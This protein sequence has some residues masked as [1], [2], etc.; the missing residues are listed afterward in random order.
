MRQYIGARYVPKFA[1]PLTWDNTHSYEALVMVDYMGDTFTSKKP[2]PA[3]VAI[4]NT[5]YWVMTGS[6]N[7]QISALSYRVDT[8]EY[9]FANNIFYT[10]PEAHGAKGDGVTDD[11]AAFK[12][13]LDTG[14]P[15]YCKPGANYMLGLIK[16]ISSCYIL[17]NNST[18][19]GLSLYLNTDDGDN[20]INSYQKRTCYI[21]NVNFE[22]STSEIALYIGGGTI[23]KNVIFN[24][25][26]RAVQFTNNYIDYVRLD[27]IKTQGS[28]TRTKSMFR[29]PSL[30]D[31]TLII[32]A[33]NT[34]GS[35]TDPAVY[36]V[37]QSNCTVFEQCLNLR[38]SIA[39]SATVTIKDCH[40]E[41]GYIDSDGTPSATIAVKRCYFWGRVALN[42]Y[43][44]YKDCTFLINN[45]TNGANSNW[46]MYDFNLKNC[47]IIIGE[48]NS[49]G[50]NT[51]I[52]SDDTDAESCA[53]TSGTN[54]I[55]S[56]AGSIV[57]GNFNNNFDGSTI[58]YIGYMTSNPNKMT[59][60]N[61]YQSEARTAAPAQGYGVRFQK[62]SAYDTSYLYLIRTINNVSEYAVIPPHTSGNYIIDF[63]FNVN[64][65][66]WK[67]FTGT[68]PTSNF[69]YSRTRYHHIPKGTSDCVNTNERYIDGTTGV[70]TVKL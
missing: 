36:E 60:H 42:A 33:H 62:G 17:G 35:N 52:N 43:A 38:I 64:G 26:D 27:S 58:T 29:L 30:S 8:L 45:M 34:E 2:V 49:I 16:G 14:L 66:K 4:S 51:I 40:F 20:W 23:L 13:A 19:T 41:N 22:C 50:G 32:N 9:D 37:R 54:S 25:Y 46:D 28:T 18:F 65:V 53:P 11:T 69:D 61:T 68:I 10:T 7:S 5:E 55:L 70:I 3:G 31:E 21:E 63:G 24:K 12:D 1:D 39:G 47:M 56:S 67:P 48:S 15:I 57:G 6:Y 44:T 59:Y